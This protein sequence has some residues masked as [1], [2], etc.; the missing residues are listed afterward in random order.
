[1]VHTL[2]R[3]YL[4]TAATFALLFTAGVTINLLINL[5]YLAGLLPRT[6]FDDGG[7]TPPPPSS[8]DIEQ[9][10]VLFFVTA[11][12]VGAI[13]GGGH[14]WLIRRDAR[15]DP[16]AD[17]GPTRH[18]FLNGLL[19]LAALVGVP[20]ALAALA[21]IDQSTGYIDTAIPLSFALVSG[22]VFLLVFL[23]RARVQPA[24][25]AA[26]L[27]RQIHEDGVQAVL[28]VIASVTLVSAVSAFIHWALVQTNVVQPVCFPLFGEGPAASA[29]ATFCSTPIISPLLEVVFILAA[30]GGYVWLGAWSRGRVLQRILW[31]AALGYGLVWLLAG[32]ALAFYT[33]LAVL[34]GAPGAWQQSLD[35]SLPFVGTLLTSVLIIVP[36]LL[37]IQW[38][39]AQKPDFRRTILQGLLAL[40]AA[41]SISFFLVGLI[42][43]LEGVVEQLVPAG[44]TLDAKGWATA[45]GMLIAGL[46]YPFLWWRLRRESDPAQEGP[47][48]PRRVYVLAVLAAT[49]IGAII[50]AVIITYQIVALLL[51]LPFADVLTARRGGV[52]L[53]V[54]GAMALSHLWQ[55][56]AD[57]RAI[58]ARAAAQPAPKPEPG[59]GAPQEAAALPMGAPASG[60]PETLESILRAVAAGALDPAAAAARIR[61]LPA[62]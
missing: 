41:V 15:S 13:F 6:T 54:L 46:G 50:A 21:G 25:R 9:S 48:I 2:K 57:L 23:E 36:Y 26:V 45:M 8:Q 10:V 31:F 3:I 55:L 61:R 37:W 12:L 32:I 34:Y 33:G 29:S 38:L 28:L 39:A 43:T 58:H 49:A 51:G 17:G 20:T 27:I 56:R 53:L 7:Y 59:A 14:Y 18:V 5:F 4:Y 35:D 22:L 19:A 1:M 42:L 52:I 62:L 47:M 40:S 60:T 11:L 30:W 44:S 24:G 16:G